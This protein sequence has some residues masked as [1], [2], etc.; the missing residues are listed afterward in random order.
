MVPEFDTP[1]IYCSTKKFDCI[2]RL[3]LMLIG[4]TR[5]WEDGMPGLLTQCFE[6]TL[7]PVNPARNSTYDFMKRFFQEVMQVFPDSLLHLGGDEVDTQC[8]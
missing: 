7:G 5:S 4:H 6:N 3:F 1:G 2:F 8:W